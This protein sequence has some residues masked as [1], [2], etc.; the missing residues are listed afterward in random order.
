MTSADFSKRARV[1]ARASGYPR[2]RIHF[3]IVVNAPQLRPIPPVL[4]SGMGGWGPIVIVGLLSG[5]VLEARAQDSSFQS[6]SRCAAET[7]S[8]GRVDRV[9]DGRSFVLDDGREIR[10]ASL[11][12]PAAA[13]TSPA[14]QASRA[15]LAAMVA[16]ETVD[17]AQAHAARP[18]ATA[19]RVAHAFTTGEARP[20]VRS[21]MP[22]WPRGMPGSAPRSAIPRAPQSCYSQERVARIAKIGPVGRPAICHNGRLGI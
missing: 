4:V 3:W 6:S 13:G 17:A 1:P 14:G 7:S 21:P 10:L 15:A 16:G 19:A 5:A 22:C 20:R 8:A 2:A 12:V 11:E 18:T 9:I